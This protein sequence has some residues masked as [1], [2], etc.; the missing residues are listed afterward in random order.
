MLPEDE[1]SALAGVHGAPGGAQ[2]EGGSGRSHRQINIFPANNFT[3]VKSWVRCPAS[4]DTVESEGRQ[5]K[6]C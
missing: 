4:P 3:V 6:Q 5:M 1:T 2:L